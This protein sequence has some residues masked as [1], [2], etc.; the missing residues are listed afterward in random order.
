MDLEAD[1]ENDGSSSTPSE[2]KPRQTISDKSANSTSTLRPLQDIQLNKSS[3][4]NLRNSSSSVA[5]P[6]TCRILLPSQPKFKREELD[7]TPTNIRSRTIKRVHMPSSSDTE[8]DSQGSLF[9]A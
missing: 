8:E 2:K 5:S 4:T 7:T 1:K 3:V 6:S 9:Y